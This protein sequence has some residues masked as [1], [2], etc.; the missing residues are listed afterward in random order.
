MKRII[1]TGGAGFIGSVLVKRLFDFY[2]HMF[3]QLLV[4][5]KLTYAANITNLGSSVNNPK[6]QLKIADISVIDDISNL[7]KDGDLIFHLAAE[8]HV[9]N[10][11]SDGEAFWR[12]NTVGTSNILEIMKHRKGVRLLYVSTDEVYGSIRNGSFTEESTLNPNSPYSASKAAGDLAC[13]AYLKTHGLDVNISR[14][15]NN[16]GSEQHGEKFLPVIVNNILNS[17]PVPIY[18]NGSNVREWIPA[19]VH[20]EYL[21]RIMY[22]NITGQIF[23]I[24]SGYELDNITMARFAAK[25]LN[26]NLEIQYIEDRKAHDFR[27]SLDISKISKLLGVIPFSPSEELAKTILDLNKL[28]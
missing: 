11:I 20:S 22:S 9:D 21:I 7:I 18:G 27:Y 3:D 1:V 6:F 5:D 2:G 24:G 4:I 17:K 19:W 14:C 12:T 10:S 28:N 16:F 26:R 8:S 13:I 23:N 25:T 15:S